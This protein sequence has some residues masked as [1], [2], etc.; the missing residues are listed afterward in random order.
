LRV[1]Q[2]VSNVDCELPAHMCQVKVTWRL[3]Q[4]YFAS[5]TTRFF[6]FFDAARAPRGAGTFCIAPINPVQITNI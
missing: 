3:Y 6:F 1:K 2:P 5:G 4:K